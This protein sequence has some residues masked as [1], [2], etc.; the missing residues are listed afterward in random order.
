MKSWKTTILG[1]LGALALLIPQV[2]AVLDGDPKTNPDV[3]QI[4][5]ALSVGGAGVAARDND[6]R[7][8]D[9]IDSSTPRL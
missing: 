2:V 4:L 5:L 7:S 8:E 3:E 6:K 1:I 9:M